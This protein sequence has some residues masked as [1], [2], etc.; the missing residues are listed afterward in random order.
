MNYQE[1]K[2]AIFDVPIEDICD[3]AEIPRSGKYILCREHNDRNF[4]SCSLYNNRYHCFACGAS[5]TAIDLVRHHFKISWM[6]A[7]RWIAEKFGIPCLD[8]NG[9]QR[10]RMPFTKKQLSLLGFQTEPGRAFAA[11]GASLF[12]PDDDEDFITTLDEYVT[13]IKEIFSLDR[14]FYEDREG[15]FFMVSS[16]A[17]Q[18]IPYF[19]TLYEIEI[20]NY[21]M[22]KC[23]GIQR[24]LEHVLSELRF[25]NA[26]LV[27]AE[28]GFSGFYFPEEKKHEARH[29]MVY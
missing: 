3:Q 22:W 6:E 21:P 15:F 9:D 5:G 25:V 12:K 16:R 8:T 17:Q 19:I 10:E 29:K 2:Q 27:R 23:P 20:W 26:A 11:L 28:C 1:W 14:L 24:A 4:G 13:G 7:A 18:V